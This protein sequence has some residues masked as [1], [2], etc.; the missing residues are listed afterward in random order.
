MKI[1]KTVFEVLAMLFVCFMF[2][3]NADAIFFSKEVYVVSVSEHFWFR[4]LAF[5]SML[6]V[7]FIANFM[8]NK[9]SRFVEYVFGFVTLCW[10]Y[11]SLL[12]AESQP[13]PLMSV[14]AKVLLFS[15]FTYGLVVGVI[16]IFKVKKADTV[17]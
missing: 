13:S 3:R 15:L 17:E 14:G 9:T 1:V 4:A 7:V 16:Y 11:A 2:S 8:Y 12:I 10:M 5:V 6:V